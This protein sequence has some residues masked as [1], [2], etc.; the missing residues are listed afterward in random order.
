MLFGGG[1]PFSIG[2]CRAAFRDTMVVTAKHV[3]A[4]RIEV[5]G[6]P[7]Y[8]KHLAEVKHFGLQSVWREK[9]RVNISDPSRTLVDV[10]GDPRIGG[11]IRHVAKSLA[12]YW[13]ADLRD[14]RRILSYVERLG[15]RVIFKRLGFLLEALGLDA[16][17]TIDVCQR[18]QSS[19]L[20]RLD[21]SVPGD[22]RI[23][24]RWN[25]RVNLDLSASDLP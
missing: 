11:G 1:P 22:G 17:S 15:N 9:V 8:L 25:F 14:D 10:L 7:Y 19:G 4:Q 23:T 5:Q 2:R 20:T 3:R 6:M 12:T 21:P 18:K 24:K 16:A 13:N